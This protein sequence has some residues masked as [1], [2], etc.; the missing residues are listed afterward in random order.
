MSKLPVIEIFGPTI[1]GEG[2]V[3]GLKT[4]FVRLYG[5]DYKCSWCDSSFTWDGSAINEINRFNTEQ[6]IERLTENGLNHCNYVTI[7]GGNPALYGTAVKQLIECL[8]SQNKQVIVETQGSL[9]QDWFPQVDMLTISPKPPSSG[10]TTNWDTLDH[11][12]NRISPQKASLKVV[13]FDDEDYQFATL[14]HQR[15]PNF[16]LYLQAGNSDV[17]DSGDI[18]KRLLTKLEWL[19]DKVLNDHSMQECRVL[20]Q[21]HA[22]I[23]NNDRGK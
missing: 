18:S 9:W 8:H 16:Q 6:I 1:Q 21:L 14:I 11:I 5:C 15:Y 20:P 10:M 3:I 4:L 7:S 23:W 2:S 17:K 22:L 19:F 13:I 12:M